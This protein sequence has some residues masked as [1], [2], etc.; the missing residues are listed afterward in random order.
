MLIIPSY[1][2]PLGSENIF[3]DTEGDLA[4]IIILNYVAGPEPSYGSTNGSEA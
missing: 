2:L 1:E 3:S 4:G